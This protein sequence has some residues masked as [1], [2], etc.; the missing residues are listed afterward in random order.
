MT[1]LR[2]IVEQIHGARHGAFAKRTRWRR[3]GLAFIVPIA[4]T[5]GGEAAAPPE[6]RSSLSG[7]TAE[8]LRAAVDEIQQMDMSVG[9]ESLDGQTDPIA[10]DEERLFQR[11]AAQR[12]GASVGRAGE[13]TSVEVEPVPLGRETPKMAPDEPRGEPSGAQSA[14]EVPELRFSSGSFTPS[15]ASTIGSSALSMRRPATVPEN[16]SPMPSL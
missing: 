13:A 12:A 3:H 9:A 11:S 1:G 16:G 5:W 6:A 15:R 14:P 10:V 2:T 4:M 8:F 7:L